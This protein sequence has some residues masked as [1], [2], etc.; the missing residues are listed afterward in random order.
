MI[1]INKNVMQT[2]N[3]VL[4]FTN[5]HHGEA[6]SNELTQNTKP[7]IQLFIQ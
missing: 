2:D 5:G 7:K 1:K 3:E 6:V 4:Y